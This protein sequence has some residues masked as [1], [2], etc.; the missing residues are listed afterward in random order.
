MKLR[1]IRKFYPDGEYFGI[2][3]KL[4]HLYLYMVVPSKYAKYAVNMLVETLKNNT[5]GS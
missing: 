3:I 2:V 1:E 4:D 5:S